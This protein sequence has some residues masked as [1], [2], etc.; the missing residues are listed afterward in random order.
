MVSQRDKE[1][2]RDDVRSRGTRLSAVDREKILNPYLP[3]PADLPSRAPQRRKKIPRKTPIRSFIKSQL[4]LLTYAILH[5]LYGI[6][7]RLFQSYH[8]VVDR[9]FAIIYYHHRTPQLIRK[10]VTSLK[11]LPGHLSVVLS[12]RKEDDALAILMDEVAELAAWTSSIPTLHH[13]MTSKLSSYYG[14]PGQQPTLQLFAP[15]HPIFKQPEGVALSN[16]GNPTTLTVLL[17]SA[18]DG[19]ETFVDLTKTLA[20]MSQSG[21]LLPEHITLELVDAEISEITTRP[22]TTVSVDGAT[23]APN[24]LILPVKPEPDLLLVFGPFLKLDGYP[25]WH[26]RLTEMFCTGGRS[27]GIAIADEAVEYHGFLRGLWH[28]AGAQMRFGR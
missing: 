27:S 19:R 18:T 28:Y 23:R 21:K 26:I 17:L 20:E 24:Q 8:A 4:H 15:H 25:P 9:I 3:D 1:L 16:K 13:I 7:I 12:L 10:D 22:T 11:R 5:V 6:V 14:T 2:F